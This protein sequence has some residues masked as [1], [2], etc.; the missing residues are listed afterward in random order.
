MRKGRFVYFG[1]VHI[2]AILGVV[3]VIGLA[4]RLNAGPPSRIDVRVQGVIGPKEL[5][6]LPHGEHKSEWRAER[7][8]IDGQ[9]VA[10]F[11]FMD[12][13]L[14]S[15]EFCPPGHLTLHSLRRERPADVR[16]DRPRAHWTSSTDTVGEGENPWAD[17]P[18]L[19]VS[20]AS[21]L[22]VPSLAIIWDG[23]LARRTL[24]GQEL[25]DELAGLSNAGELPE[26]EAGED[27]P[28]H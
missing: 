4:A 14:S 13:Q 22:G 3:Q 2:L 5:P 8:F 25:W 27:A 28:D 11:W 1:A 9:P 19:S 15:M 7:V 18:M 16:S 26:G 6:V 20:D 17:F 10:R 23:T 24:R 12:D 21:G